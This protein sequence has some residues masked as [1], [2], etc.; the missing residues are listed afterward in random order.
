MRVLVAGAGPVGLAFACA[1]RGFDV[2]VIDPAPAPAPPE[3]FD[4]R[5]FALS[6]GSRA[7]LRDVGAWDELDAARIAPVRRMEIFGDAGGRM[8]FAG[9]PAAPLAWIVEAGRL[10]SALEAH[11]ASQPGV[12]IR[13]G[14][15]ARDYG[16]DAARVFAELGDGTRLEGAL[17]VGADGADSR[18]R[19]LLGLEAQTHDYSE[20]A[21][22]ANF[23]VEQP[24]GDTARQW[25]GR[26]G[27][28]AWLPL[29]GKR[30]SI[31]WSAP[32]DVARAL[33]GADDREFERRVRDSGAAAL[34]DLR[35]VSRRVSFPLRMVRVDRVAAP[36]V[37]LIGDAA[38]SV[39]PLAGQGVNLGFQD[40]RLLAEE[41]TTR[42]P[43]ERPGDLRVLRRYAR[44]RRED[45]SAMQF[46]TT[47]LDALFAS[48]SPFVGDMR[49]AGL[50]MV[51]SQP[52]LKALLRERAMR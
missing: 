38:H 42:S 39:H 16:A 3:D 50:G 43:L 17:L 1:C 36:G 32:S 25:F 41:L 37:T 48:T 11:A 5:I 34:G 10:A 18:V 35:L 28:M 12:R 31:V 26:E 2:E 19:A 51:Q 40:A 21:V 33:M 6:P 15:E 30:I 52:W 24:H 20:E 44:G 7:F 8:T 13:R 9:R 46:V 23:E 47:R 4:T 45:V 14:I 27:V 22:V 49:N 29:P